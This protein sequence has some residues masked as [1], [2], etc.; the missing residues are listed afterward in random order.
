MN[1][2]KGKDSKEETPFVKKIL[3]EYDRLSQDLIPNPVLRYG[4]LALVIFASPFI[5]LFFIETPPNQNSVYYSQYER[6]YL[7]NRYQTIQRLVDVYSSMHLD[8]GVLD[9][10]ETS[11]RIIDKINPE[12]DDVFESLASLYYAGAN[13]F[14]SSTYLPIILNTA[15]RPD[16]FSTVHRSQLPDNYHISENIHGDS[17]KVIGALMERSVK[18]DTLERHYQEMT[19]Y[20]NEQ[21]IKAAV[22]Q[23]PALER[24]FLDALSFYLE[25]NQILP[26]SALDYQSDSLKRKE[27]QQILQDEDVPYYARF[28]I[29]TRFQDK[30]FFNRL[31][32]L[33]F[34][35]A[36][37]GS[38]LPD[39]SLIM[40]L[41]GRMDSVLQMPPNTTI[42]DFIDNLAESSAIVDST[43]ILVID[44]LKTLSKANP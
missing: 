33:Y 15:T 30:I 19:S 36:M 13:L 4:L 22:L 11:K 18:L 8:E 34:V 14:L 41:A 28:I 12:K 9:S 24:D 40:H 1:D 6:I 5:T 38:L 16:A 27:Y 25:I 32:P 44:A 7:I 37:Q 39:Q 43:S 21:N 29:V 10:Y 26:A 23:V 31:V 2:F 35:Y 20:L 17:V 3:I 42:K